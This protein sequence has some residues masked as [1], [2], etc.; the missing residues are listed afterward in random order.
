MGH[1][2]MFMS[3]IWSSVFEDM[4]RGYDCDMFLY[5]AFCTHTICS[6]ITYAVTCLRI[7]SV[8]S[9]PCLLVGMGRYLKGS[10]KTSYDL[11][12]TLDL[13]FPE[14]RQT[15]KEPIRLRTMLLRL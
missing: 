10:L 14:T 12:S 9:F 13:H 11:P 6:K 15:S 2:A 3:E 5:I 7:F 8:L 4:T 1:F